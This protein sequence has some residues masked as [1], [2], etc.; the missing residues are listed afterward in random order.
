MSESCWHLFTGEYPPRPGGVGDY[1]ALLAG[2]IAATGA[3]V[4]V[5]T[6]AA[7]GPSAETPGVTVHRVAGTWSPRDLSAIGAS[8]DGF[9]PPRRLL[10][11]YTPNAWG[12]RGL[13]FP[14]C[15]WLI[16][17]GRDRGD[18]VR[19]MFHEV[20]FPFELRGKP[21]RWLL[22]A[23][24]RR[25][26]RMVLEAATHVDLATTAWQPTL[27]ALS[28]GDLRAFGWR[29]VPSNIPVCV[30]A[31][32]VAEARRRVAP[33]GE[34]VVG[35]FGSFSERVAL[36]LAD[37]FPRLLLNRPDRVGV[38]IGRHGERLAGRLIAETPALGGR[39]VAPGAQD[40]ADAS[41]TLQA[42]AVLVQP[43]PDG[44]TTR[45]GSL[46]AA[47]AHGIPTVTNSGRLTEPIWAESRGVALAPGID[48]E[49]LAR[50]VDW[51]LNDHDERDRLGAAGR[52]L[53]ERWFSVARTVEAIVGPSRR[54]AP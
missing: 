47:I 46:M 20:A 28:R 44:A 50:T 26:A 19:V 35:S 53:H 22:A 23:G 30:D 18:E 48:P 17:R 13:N 29:P 14:F 7:D 9:D 6:T 2:A 15:R 8:L 10:V 27:R 31:E 11:Q 4:H 3:A 5:W 45:R 39:I 16:G 37:L 24:Q 12:R 41:R 1:S 52:D 43:Y 34:T 40:S 25:M 54:V 32:G 42:C 33:G 49:S 36:M 51:V 38:L 21:T